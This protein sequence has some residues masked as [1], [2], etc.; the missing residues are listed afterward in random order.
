MIAEEFDCKCSVNV[1]AALA[2]HGTFDGFLFAL[3][4][5][6]EDG[7]GRKFRPGADLRTV[8]AA[9]VGLFI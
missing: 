1:E 2:A 4:R 3:A 7:D 6:E 9:L 5:V 8:L